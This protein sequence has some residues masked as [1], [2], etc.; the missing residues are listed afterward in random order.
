MYIAGFIDELEKKIGSILILISFHKNSTLVHFVQT[1]TRIV[2]CCLHKLKLCDLILIVAKVSL[3][4][5][6][7]E[8]HTNG[9]TM[10]IIMIY[11][12]AYLIGLH[13]LYTLRHRALETQKYSFK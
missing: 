6:L 4:H 11:N 2:M 13:T 3:S 1:V 9:I 7:C 10:I 5:A 8:S 12:M